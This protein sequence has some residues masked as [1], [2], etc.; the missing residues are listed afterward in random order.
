MTTLKDKRFW[1]E[2]YGSIYPYLEGST[3]YKD[4]LKVF[5]DNLDLKEG[6]VILDCGAGSGLLVKMIIEK[7]NGNVKIDALDF[8]QT[9][10]DHLEE[11]IRIHG[12]QV[13]LI[14]HDLTNKLPFNDNEYDRFVSNLVLTYIVEHEGKRGKESLRGVLK[15]AYRVLKEG[16]K[17]VWSTPIKDVKFRKVFM[18]SWKD[19]LDLRHWKRLYYG[20]KILSHAFKIE[21]RGKSGEYNFFEKKEIEDLLLDVGFKEIKFTKSFANQAMVISCEK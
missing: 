17:F 3:P 1:G 10:L 14:K 5:I 2:E 19:M 16:G 12:S 11:K 18:A 6:Q 20:P 4:L 15:E 8:S 9:M 13:K 21:K 7:M